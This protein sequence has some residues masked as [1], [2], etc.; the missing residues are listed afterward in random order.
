MKIGSYTFALVLGAF[1]SV[2]SATQVQG[3][4]SGFI[5]GSVEEL[6]ESDGAK[7]STSLHSDFS[8]ALGAEVLTY[9]VNYLMVGGGIGFYSLQ[10]DGGDN[11]V[12]PAIPVW[13]SVGVIGPKAW[14][15]RPYFE[16]RIG[17]AFPATPLSTWWSK[18]LNFLV[19]ANLGVHLPYHMGVE[20]NCTYLSMNKNFK[21]DGVNFRLSAVKIGGSVTV[22][23]DL[24]GGSTASNAESAKKSNAFEVT[25]EP[26]AEPATDDNLYGYPSSEGTESSG[27]G[28]S[29]YD[30]TGD[31]TAESSAEPASGYGS[32]ESSAA[33]SS[34]VEE[35]AEESSEGDVAE[36]TPA[37]EAVEAPAPEAKPEPAAQKTSK[38]K[39]AKKST[40]K[41]AKKAAKKSTKKT[42]KKKK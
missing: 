25:P 4:V 41:K 14:T 17:Y 40:K 20:F 28:E 10:K 32:E 5:P 11:V 8:W 23:F 1:A 15:A 29:S 7:K 31:Q 30:S 34:T 13:A 18:P 35:P 2:S 12:M 33:E 37:E 24:F 39:A 42:S 3:F 27:Y 26:A 16:A 6:M 9:P 36:E 38:K 22:H 19:G 21:D